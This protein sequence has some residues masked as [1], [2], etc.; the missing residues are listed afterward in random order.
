MDEIVRKLEGK[1]LSN[2]ELHALL[3]GSRILNY[4]ELAQYDSLDDA[5]G[6][7]G[8]MIILYQSREQ[9]GV[10]IHCTYPCSFSRCF[11]ILQIF[12]L[13]LI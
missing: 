1:S 2:F 3:P 10:R 4:G 7:D 5:F 8:S 13:A 12:T 6:P 9:Y 11:F